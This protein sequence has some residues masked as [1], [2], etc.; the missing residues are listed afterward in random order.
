MRLRSACH[1][2]F[3][4]TL[5]LPRMLFRI[6]RLTFPLTASFQLEWPLVY[7]SGLSAKMVLAHGF[8]TQLKPNKPPIVGFVFTPA[9]LTSSA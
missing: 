9:L 3:S 6:Q 1:I 8:M 7:Q 5:S 2:I 4:L